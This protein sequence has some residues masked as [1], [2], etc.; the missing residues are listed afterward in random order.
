MDEMPRRQKNR[1]VLVRDITFATAI[2]S[3]PVFF[4]LLNIAMTPWSDSPLLVAATIGSCLLSVVSGITSF[5]TAII[6][7]AR[8]KNNRKKKWLFTCLVPVAGFAML[9]LSASITMPPSSARYNNLGGAV[10]RKSDNTAPAAASDVTSQPTIQGQQQSSPGQ[11][12]PTAQQQDTLTQKDSTCKKENIVSHGTIYED[13]SYLYPE[14]SYTLEGSDGYDYV[15]PTLGGFQFKA[16]PVNTIVRRGT[17]S[18]G[19][20]AEQLEQQRVEAEQQRAREREDARARWSMCAQSVKSQI[21]TSTDPAPY[22][23]QVCGNAP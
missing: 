15:C 22:I 9:M 5:V 2:V 8:S 13:A 7:S 23:Q 11:Q 1:R 12:L 4:I 6:D 21:G 17:R 16:N 19:P 20:S 10:T 18:H 3:I 14:E